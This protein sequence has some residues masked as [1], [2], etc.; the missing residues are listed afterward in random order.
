[1]AST[2][3]RIEI[4]IRARV[5]GFRDAVRGAEVEL[6]RMAAVVKNNDKFFDRLGTS[7]GKTLKYLAAAGAV[8]NAVGGIVA[9][10][11][12][13]SNLLGIV[14]VAPAALFGLAAAV[15]T[16]KLA[17]AG[18]GDALGG[19]AEALAKLAPAARET[20]QEVNRL[21]PAFD[22]LRKSVQQEFFK[23][24]ATD[25]RTISNQ[26]LPVL[27]RQLPRISSAFNDM[28]RSIT[29]ALVTEGANGLGGPVGD[30]HRSGQHGEVPGERAQFRRPPGD[31]VHPADRCRLH[32]PPGPRPV[33]RCELPTG[34]GC[35]RCGSPRTGPCGS[36]SM[37]RSGSSA[38]CAT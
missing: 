36:G 24:F 5:E 9:L 37:T 17:T 12:S 3:S 29:R 33:D 4:E 20:V 11:A 26:Y 31:R 35:S 1:M 22:A 13:L 38:S 15:G 21:K 34:S 32:L 8:G 18:F 27:E 30:Q 6:R 19:D 14:G 16:F 25:L 7:I 2:R 28:G 23:N 10:T